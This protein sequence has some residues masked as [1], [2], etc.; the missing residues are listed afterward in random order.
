MNIYAETALKL[1]RKGYTPIP[2]TGKRPSVQNWQNAR[3]VKPNQINIWERAG[4]FQNVGMVTGSASN[5]TVVIDFDGMEGYRRFC[6]A[7]PDLVDTLTVATGSGEGMHVYL[8]VD[9]L[10]DSRA[11]LNIPHG[12][13]TFNVEIKAD[14]KQVVIPPS[15]HPDTGCPYIYHKRVEI[16]PVTDI[17][18]V[19]NWAEGMQNGNADIWTPPAAIHAGDDALN[20]VLLAAV[21]S[22]FL[23]IPHKTHG[24]WINCSCPNTNNHKHGDKNFSFGYNRDGY[25][26]CYV[27]GTML[28][29]D[30]LPLI[31]MDAKAYGG[32]FE[33]SEPFQVRLAQAPI[34]PADPAPDGLPVVIRSDRLSEYH[35]RLT[36]Y[37]AP[38][39]SPPI[40]FPLKVLHRYGG[41]A[42]V[43]RAGKLIG[44]VGTSGG[45]KTSLLETMVDGWLSYNVPCLIWSP[46]W[47]ADEFIERAVQRYGGPT[48]TELYKHEIFIYER[49]QGITGGVGVEVSEDQLRRAEKA[50]RDIRKWTA[51]IGY[52]NDPFLTV[53]KLRDSMNATLDKLRFTPRVLIIDYVQLLH[54]METT[55]DL[56]MYKLLMVIKA[57]CAAHQLV[58]VI[59]SQ[60]TKAA[61]KDAQSGDALDAQSAR[62]VNDDAFNLYVTITPDRD[63][64]GMVRD[65]AILNVVKN[66]YGTRGKIRVGVDWP[67]MTFADIA[68]S[69]QRFE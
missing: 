26:H 29:K 19:L 25:G 21:E 22:Y 31:Q 68:H 51:Q 55:P 35:A 10:P 44:I 27:C 30:L 4:L 2:L 12:D 65:S 3:N 23:S 64:T 61:A 24:E 20:P 42:E 54:A 18:A 45:G 33:K 32:L 36:D 69:N 46:E 67:R 48:M 7:F 49:Q 40:Y 56:T 58:G 57:T 39:V 11:F 47:T 8:K 41:M 1:A 28:L 13:E 60:T 52:I 43:M 38:V 62:W 6:E 50:L 9:L 15:V 17:S 34:Q 53:G 63:E 5:N 14:G 37:D 66:S 59:A 16:K